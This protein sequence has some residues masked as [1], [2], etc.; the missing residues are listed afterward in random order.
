M[1]ANITIC[2]VVSSVLFFASCGNNTTT[3]QTNTDS[4][5]MNKTD[6]TGKMN[7]EEMNKMDNGLMGSMNNMM[8][9]MS[10]MKMT[11][12]F[13]VDFASMMIE[14]HQG[15]IDMSEAEIKSGTDEKLKAMAQNII[16]KQKEEQGKLRV[17]L[18]N[19]KPMKMD[20]GQGDALNKEMNEMKV[21][22]SA[23]KMSG[24]TDKNFTLMM[25]SHHQSA[26]KMAKAEL[27]N[28]MNSSLKQLAKKVIDDQTNEIAEFKTI[29]ASVK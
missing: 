11:G 6:T 8:G 28:G 5:Q 25:I 23:M 9:K 10:S 26:I 2:T 14:H 13:D 12:D 4:T 27:A 1:K 24:S 20:M 7:A 18:K 15:A 22:M 21:N 19:T 29:L 17:I 3:V 16:I